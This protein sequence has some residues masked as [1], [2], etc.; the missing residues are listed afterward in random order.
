MSG[1]VLDENG[2]PQV[3]VIVEVDYSTTSGASIPPS[4]CPITPQFCWLATRTNDEG[5]YEVEFEPSTWPTRE[6]R[7]PG[8]LG[9][10]YSFRSGYD[11]DVQWVPA[12]GSPAVRDLKLRPTRKIPA[13][14]SIDVTVD[15]TS[16]LCTDLEDLWM[17]QNRCALVVVDSGAGILEV[18]ARTAPG[19]PVPLL[20]WYTTGNYGG[21]ITRPGP[22]LVSIPARGGTYLILVGLPEGA[23]AQSFTVTTHLR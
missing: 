18:E 12:S 19:G 10:V 17:L 8:S 16:S 13:G 4:R 20:F 5:R 2:V 11:L 14:G 3:G 6:L 1:R 9:Y 22:G 7:A 15:S 21:F 23:P